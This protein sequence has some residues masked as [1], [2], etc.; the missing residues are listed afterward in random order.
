AGWALR[1]DGDVRGVDALVA[2]VAEGLLAEHVASD[3]G[4]HRHLSA[5]AGSHDGLVGALAAEARV[6]GVPRERLARPGQPGRPH[7]QVQVRGT[8]DTD[9]RGTVGHEL[10]SRRPSRTGARR[11]GEGS[12]G[13]LRSYVTLE[14]EWFPAEQLI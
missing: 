2:V 7:G 8:D 6:K 4:D 11:V 12:T 10:R 3:L 9:S 1:V 14:P 5:E 13:F